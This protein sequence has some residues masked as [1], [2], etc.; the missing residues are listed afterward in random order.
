MELIDKLKKQLSEEYGINNEKELL[1]AI[2]KQKPIDISIF[3]SNV[4]EILKVG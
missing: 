3:T 1:E 4:S 2:E